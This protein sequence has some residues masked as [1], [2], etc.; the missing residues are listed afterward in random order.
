[1]DHA[2]TWPLRGHEETT[3]CPLATHSRPTALD[4]DQRRIEPHMATLDRL[5]RHLD[6]LGDDDP[7]L[8]D[9]QR[10][11]EP[12]DQLAAGL[13][14]LDPGSALCKPAGLRGARLGQLLVDGGDLDL[15]PL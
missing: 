5:D 14:V 9:A 7:L 4:D 15:E 11:P 3:G 10:L 12:L 13:V 1:I 6:Q 8:L 2:A